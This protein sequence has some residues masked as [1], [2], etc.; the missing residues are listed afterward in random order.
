[1][2]MSEFLTH[3]MTKRWWTARIGFLHVTHNSPY[4]DVDTRGGGETEQQQ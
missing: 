3:G 2:I 4:V 1:M